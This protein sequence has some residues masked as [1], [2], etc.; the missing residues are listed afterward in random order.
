[1]NNKK[2]FYLVF[3]I[4]CLIGYGQEVKSPLWND[5]D[6]G[7][8]DVGY[9]TIYS[10]DTTRSFA[11]GNDYTSD[12]D[13]RPIRIMLWYPGNRNASDLVMRFKD[14]VNVS[15]DDE[16]FNKYNDILQSRDS[17]VA[18]YQFSPLSDSLLNIMM[19]TKTAAYNN[20]EMVGD[21]FPL[22][23][24]ATGMGDFQQENTVL[25]EYLASYGYIVA[26]LP[27]YGPNIN[28]LKLPYSAAGLDLQVKD[29]EF[30]LTILLNDPYVDKDR[31]GFAGHSFGGLVAWQFAISNKYIKALVSLDGSFNQFDGQSVLRD[32]REQPTDLK[33]PILNMYTL[34]N[35]K[36]NINFID[37]AWNTDRYH[38]LFKNASHYDFQNWPV[39]AI[40]TKTTDQRTVN[41]RSSE[42]GRD[43]FLI[44]V[45]LTKK[46]LDGILKEDTEALN[47]FIIQPDKIS[48]PDSIAEFRFVKSVNK[49]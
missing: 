38:V 22:I 20:I 7:P 43:I 13:A 39:Y 16:R 17:L 46:F 28:Q 48:I 12:Y 10:F 6:P 25:W 30:A 15:P 42:T 35:G 45:K 44:V 18:K 36:R 49:N 40:L 32:L 26:V 21:S 24:Y 1:M 14:Y 5:L 29:F 23:L 4:I 19:E 8:Y 31:I 9:K 3:I 2:I 47:T 37:S 41:L 34:K 27:E 11:S 33:V